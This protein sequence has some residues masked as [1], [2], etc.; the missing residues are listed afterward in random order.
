ML[1]KLDTEN[2][3]DCALLTVNLVCERVSDSAKLFVKARKTSFGKLGTRTV[4]DDLPFCGPDT[5]T[6]ILRPIPL[7]YL[8][9]SVKMSN[10]VS[11][12]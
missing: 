1:N 6:H 7:I 5:K 12:T 9:I 4:N 11:V 10:L 8:F 3:G 2:G